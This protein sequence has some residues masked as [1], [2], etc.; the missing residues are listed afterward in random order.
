MQSHR[1]TNPL[2]G[3]YITPHEATD[4]FREFVRALNNIA[5]DNFD[6]EVLLAAKFA[7]DAWGRL[8][9]EETRTTAQNTVIEIANDS[10]TVYPIP[11]DA[12]DPW[13]LEK[14]TGD[15]ILEG[16]F[17]QTFENSLGAP[18][19]VKLWVGVLV[20]GVLAGQSPVAQQS[21]IGSL[22]C[23]WAVPVGAGTHRIE[24][25]FSHPGSPGAGTLTIIWNE[26]NH[27]IREVAR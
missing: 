26:G 7:L 18:A 4:E 5:E 10:G 20:D 9:D 6:D 3:Q 2:P 15:C 25:V 13:V 23:D 21:T 24:M 8:F 19:E 14:T 16:S 12:G 22:D 17:G 1:Q 27:I 11:N